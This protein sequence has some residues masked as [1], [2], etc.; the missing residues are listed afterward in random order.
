MD[1][2]EQFYSV[3]VVSSSE[4]F[5]NAMSGLLPVSRYDPVRYVGGISAAKRIL[6]D[7]EFDFVI[8]N[9]P[10]PDGAGTDL[11]IDFSNSG[12]ELY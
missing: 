2:K 5:N 10:L 4:A 8:I 12:G 6:T 3:L 7:R 11:A 1:L 9:S